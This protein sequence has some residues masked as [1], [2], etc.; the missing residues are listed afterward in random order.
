MKKYLFIIQGEGRGHISQAICL[1]SILKQEGDAVSL[2]LVGS[3]KKGAIPDY[4]SKQGIE[5]SAFLTPKFSYESGGVLKTTISTIFNNL[6][7]KK[8]FQY[9]KSIKHIRRSIM[10]HK[11]DIVINFFEPL[12]GLA[13]LLTRRDDVV[14][15]SVAHQFLSLHPSSSYGDGVKGVWQIRL[16]S[17]ICRAGSKRVLA[18]SHYPIEPCVE[19]GI[20]AVP[21]LIR[22]DIIKSQPS[23][24]EHLLGYALN[25]LVLG[26]LIEWHKSNHN[27]AID[28]FVNSGSAKNGINQHSNTDANEKLKIHELNDKLFIEKM[29]QC[30]GYITTGGFESVCEAAFLGKPVMMV[31]LHSEQRCN[32]KEAQDLGLGIISDEFTP[33]R[34]LEFIEQKRKSCVN[35]E[36]ILS[37]HRIFTNHLREFYLPPL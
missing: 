22:E 14:F 28:L 36:W 30:R 25:Q 2:F 4:L 23:T 13:A 24:G 32:A 3:P 15:V 9:Y 29:A 26:E 8:I 35:R 10:E 33:H 7:P 1:S 34:L 37:S 5:V 6:S 27:I 31:P 18:L 16:L 19:K 12:G 21:P 17:K 11:P 20:Y